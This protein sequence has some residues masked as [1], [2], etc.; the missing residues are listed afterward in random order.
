MHR[1][2]Y[3]IPGR[4]RLGKHG[5]RGRRSTPTGTERRDPTR[6]GVQRQLP[7][8]IRRDY[9]RRDVD[10]TN[11]TLI[12]GRRVVQ[13]FGEAHRWSPALTA[14]FD[15]A[16]VV[17]LSGHTGDEKIR[18]SE[19]IST[20]RHRGRVVEILDQ[21]GLLDDDRAPAFEAC[22]ERQLDGITPAS[23][24]VEDWIRALHDG[25]LRLR[26]R[27]IPRRLRR[28]NRSRLRSG[29]KLYAQVT[30]VLRTSKVISCAFGVFAELR[31]DRGT[32]REWTRTSFRP[33][34]IRAM[35]VK[36]G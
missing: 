1:D 34:S 8:D 30:V 6:A 31:A 35:T 5:T 20:V 18:Y 19:L 4:A 9:R 25:G 22:L 16:L 17:V 7:L 28:W 12:R 29:G 27:A 11:R 10:L 13:D 33:S 15:Q 3:R 24:D 36:L 21:L 2:H 23:G 14:R 32:V 26:P